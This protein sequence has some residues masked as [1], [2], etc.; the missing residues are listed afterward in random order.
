MTS[1]AAAALLASLL[2]GCASAPPEAGPAR[3]SYGERLGLFAGL[4]QAEDT[5]TFDAALFYRAA[6]SP[7][8]WLRGKA[9]LA[10]GRLRDPSASALLPPLLTDGNPEVRRA[11]A[12]AA[13]V[14]GDRSLAGPL[15][16][17]LG[18]SDGET[19]DR[20]AEA[21]GK[22]GGPEATAALLGA[23]G[24][25]GPH[26]AAAATALWRVP[27]PKA[28]AALSAVALDPSVPVA[29]RR[30]A[31]Y[32]LARRPRPEGAATVRSVLRTA[33]KVG[34]PDAVAWAA[35]AAG[36]LA[37][38]E[39][40]PDLLRLAES[41]SI[42]IGVQSLL[43]LERIASSAKDGE[44]AAAAA[45]VA[46]R[47][48]GDAAAGVSVA[49]LRLLGALS[50]TAY[51]Q[52]LLEE[53]V[54]REGWKGQTALVSLTRLDAPGAPVAAA[55]RLAEAAAS[56]SLELKLGACEA[57]DFLPVQ[58]AVPAA[59][60]LLADSSSRVRAAALS[61]VSKREAPSRAAWLA[62]GLKDPSPTVRAAA[63]EGGAPLVDGALP[64]LL[65][66]WTAAFEASLRSAE[67]DDVVSAL[68]AAAARG[69]RGR[70]L[71][72]ARVDDVEP[73]IRDAARRLMAARF[74]AD[75]SSF[76][77][78]PVPP[79]Y[80][81]AAYSNLART[82]NESALTAEV[83][84][85]RGI[86]AIDLATE[87]APATVESFV[88]LARRGYFDG[89]VIHRVVPDFV[90]Q[91]GDP[92]G[93]GSGGPGYA[94]RDELN[95]LRYLRGTVGMA[96]SGPDTGG[97]QWFVALASQPHLDGGYTVF[98]RVSDG[99]EVLDRV[100]QDDRLVSVRIR[101]GR[102][103]PPPGASR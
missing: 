45:D 95:P 51:S 75:P 96:L 29:V 4:L 54:R 50:A 15:A 103:T 71:V 92:R 27:D 59:A 35:R 14:S 79:R 99:L 40:V 66:A 46:L 26:R 85:S 37:D 12:F 77:R 89:L 53:N 61:S 9:A 81:R 86:F 102:R 101:E 64:S 10:A 52:A 43:A 2:G 56:G 6:A 70:P 1:R 41:E 49:A 28:S 44:R 65:P 33:G 69:E 91:T 24:R 39:S 74:G 72:A 98:G 13:G 23:L 17:L 19:A 100:E 73:V 21:L 31:V 94:I 5:R 22:L 38:A 8:G 20:A 48:S 25:T 42:S 18:D 68:E 82:A 16:A 36:L 30:G 57:L 83:V 90:V 62:E 76:R 67:P 78:I 84:T 93:D 63:L 60:R 47:R 58:F 80:D 7:D 97:S 88:S 3:G 32:G 55:N 34:D 87:E 11:A